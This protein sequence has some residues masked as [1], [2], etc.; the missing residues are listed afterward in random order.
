MKQKLIFHYYSCSQ[1]DGYANL[2]AWVLTRDPY[3]TLDTIEQCLDIFI[4]NG[5]DVADFIT[6]WPKCFVT[7]ESKIGIS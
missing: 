4:D 1:Y 6:G 7:T 3:P 2:S 5:V